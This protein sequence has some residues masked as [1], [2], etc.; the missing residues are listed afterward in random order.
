MEREEGLGWAGRGVEGIRVGD[1]RV[2]DL[3]GGLWIFYN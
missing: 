3:V 2:W 1:G